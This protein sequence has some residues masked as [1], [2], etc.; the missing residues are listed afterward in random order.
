MPPIFRMSEVVGKAAI[1]DVAPGGVDPE[2]PYDLM[3]RPLIDPDNWL[4]YLYFHSDLDYMEVGYGPTV[5]TISHSSIAAVTASDGY[6]VNANQLVY[7]TTIT[8]HT[9]AVHSF[10]Y[11]PDFMVVV[12]GD[13]LYPGKPVQW[14]GDG[15][16]RYVT[17]YATT[18]HLY[19]EERA[20]KTPN[21]IPAV[22]KDYTIII[23]NQP[24][25]PIGSQ[26]AH[27]N[28]ATSILSLAFGKFQSD[29]RYLQLGAGGS[30]FGFAQGRTIDLNN[31][32]PRMV[33]PDG[34]I[35]DIVPAGAAT[36]FAGGY[37]TSGWVYGPSGAYGGS[38]TGDPSI[39]VKVP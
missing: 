17:A 29:R 38:F 7:D 31:G 27:W 12:D 4:D 35:T 5:T 6:T 13:V 32:A 11:V 2:D 8:T 3:H 15:R 16:T 22:S 36:A 20:S 23:F 1:Y 28:P 18:T 14:Y 30:P 10:G 34:T 25:A 26:L 37:Q 21:T 33:D 39:Q 24:P 9:L 19:L